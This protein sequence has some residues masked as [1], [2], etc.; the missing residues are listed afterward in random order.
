MSAASVTQQQWGEMLSRIAQMSADAGARDAHLLNVKE[1]QERMQA[2]IV[3]S[4]G[5]L[6]SVKNVVQQSHDK[7]QMLHGKL[8]EARVARA[9]VDALVDANCISKPSTFDSSDAKTFILWSFK[10][11]NFVTGIFPQAELLLDWWARSREDGV[12]AAVVQRKCDEIGQEIEIN[13]QLHIALA[14]LLDGE[15]LPITMDTRGRNGPDAWRKINRRFDPQT[16]A[17]KKDAVTRIMKTAPVAIGKL[18]HTQSNSGRTWYLIAKT[19]KE[20]RLMKMLSAQH[21]S[22]YAQTSYQV[23]SS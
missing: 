21:S 6:T 15:A 11:K 9:K 18:S 10:F 13:N 12:S 14:G 16:S 4:N 7:I 22:A 2:I 8:E 3:K 17:R 19:Q 5:E 23:V 20:N 1:E